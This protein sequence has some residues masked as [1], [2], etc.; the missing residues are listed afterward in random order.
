MARCAYCEQDLPGTER[1]CRICFEKLSADESTRKWRVAELWPGL[2]VVAV[3]YAGLTFLPAGVFDALHGFSRFVSDMSLA[4]QL[5]LFAVVAGLAIRN[6]WIWKSW[7]RLFFWMTGVFAII[8]LLMWI[9][10]ANR[11]WEIAG[12]IS[13]FVSVSLRIVSKAKEY[14][15]D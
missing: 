5:V 6:S 11:A 9:N 12:L 2:L 4:V 15:E 7:L 3:V 10:D 13:I 1:V 14:W 8:A